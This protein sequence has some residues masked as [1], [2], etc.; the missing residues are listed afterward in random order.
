MW[1]LLLWAVVAC[2]HD[3]A[4]PD[5]WRTRDT[6]TLAIGTTPVGRLAR[7][8]HQTGACVDS[9]RDVFITDGPPRDSVWLSWQD[10][11]PA[12]PLTSARVQSD[13]RLVRPAPDGRAVLRQA[14]LATC[15]LDPR[16]PVTRWSAGAAWGAGGTLVAPGYAWYAGTVAVR[17][18]MTFRRCVGGATFTAGEGTSLLALG[19]CVFRAAPPLLTGLVS[20]DPATP[21]GVTP[22]D[23]LRL[24]GLGR[25]AGGP[26][27]RDTL[28]LHVEL[29][30][31]EGTARGRRDTALVVLGRRIP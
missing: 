18:S 30:R 2:R 1:G 20:L 7:Q 3:A 28:V 17:D 22:Q 15:A 4:A 25:V 5:G 13:G 6:R 26:D 11:M 14:E 24:V 29:I 12:T 27:S 31:T 23:Q 16:A 9:V 8:A 21:G 10:S 19:G